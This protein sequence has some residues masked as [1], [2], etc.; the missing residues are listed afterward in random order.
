MGV[1]GAVPVRGSLALFNYPR[2]L[3]DVP[4]TDGFGRALADHVDLAA[5]DLYRGRER[6]V[7]RYYAFRR[8]LHM[9]AFEGYAD[10]CRGDEEAAAALE[11]VYGVDGVDKVD[12]MVGM[13]AERKMPGFAI[14][15]TAFFIFILMASRRLEADRFFTTEFNEETCTKTGLHGARRGGG[16]GTFCRGTCRPWRQRFQ[17]VPR[18][19]RRSQGFQ[20]PDV[21]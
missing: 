13:L 9:K 10:M 5:L 18:R 15:E 21:Q 3:R 16:C 17:P 12:L 19:S 6:G 20:T 11:E 14:S 1:A 4:P 2:A 8:E 7:R